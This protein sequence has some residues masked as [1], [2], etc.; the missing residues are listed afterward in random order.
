MLINGCFIKRLGDK[1][2]IFF[3][4]VCISVHVLLITAVMIQGRPL[5]H[6]NG[7]IL[8]LMYMEDEDRC[9][10]FDCLSDDFDLGIFS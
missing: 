2:F 6:L 8:Y 10:S 7:Y 4:S 9:C 1:I 3:L 5:L